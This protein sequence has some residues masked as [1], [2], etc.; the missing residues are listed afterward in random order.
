MPRVFADAAHYIAI[1]IPS[2]DLHDAALRAG[3]ELAE[4]EIFT[5]EAVLVEVLAYIAELGSHI[6]E[7][8]AAFV[9]RV[10]NDDRI[11]VIPQSRELFSRALDLY[12]TRL[13]KGYSLTDCMSMLVCADLNISHVLSHDHHFEQEGLTIL[14]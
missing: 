14:L 7:R 3:N 5:T 12:R 8:G 9:D 11:S 13:D 10:L 4:A 1:L 6:R 2:D